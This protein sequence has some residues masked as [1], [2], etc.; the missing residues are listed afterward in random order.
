[1]AGPFLVASPSATKSGVVNLGPLSGLREWNFWENDPRQGDRP[2]DAITAVQ[3]YKRVPWLFRAVNLRANTLADIPWAIYRGTELVITSDKDDER[4]LP[5]ELAWLKPAA[6][7]GTDPTQ[8]SLVDLIRKTEL[9]LC[10]AGA[11]YWKRDANRL[12]TM[13]Y[14]RCCRPRSRP[15]STATPAWSASSDRCPAPKKPRPSRS[16]TWCSGGCPPS[17]PSSAPAWHPRWSRCARPA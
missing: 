2:Q 1:M 13:G 12:R 8:D 4:E 9:D 6:G 7:K 10:L 3:A 11:A 15:T 16:R 14:R 17:T 5:A